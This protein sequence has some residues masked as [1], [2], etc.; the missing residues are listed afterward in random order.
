MLHFLGWSPTDLLML[1]GRG[2]DDEVRP[3]GDRKL[4]VQFYSVLSEALHGLFSVTFRLVMNAPDL[5]SA[6]SRP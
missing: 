3:I 1:L 5:Y 6:A 2:G 4:E